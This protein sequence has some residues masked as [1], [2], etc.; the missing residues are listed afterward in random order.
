VALKTTVAIDAASVVQLPSYGTVRRPSK[1]KA[2]KSVKVFE[3]TKAQ[4]EEIS[5]E[6]RINHQEVMALLSEH[7]LKL[8]AEQQAAAINP[9]A[10]PP[11]P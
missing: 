7:F 11:K 3:A 4:I 8:T 9:K 10:F 2:S 5:R 1:G 6:W